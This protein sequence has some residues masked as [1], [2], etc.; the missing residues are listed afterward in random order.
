[1]NKRSIEKKCRSFF[2]FHEYK[3]DKMTTLSAPVNN[4]ISLV[5]SLQ[6]RSD[7]E[8]DM[9]TW[10]AQQLHSKASGVAFPV[11]FDEAWKRL[12][13]SRKDVAKRSLLA[14]NLDKNQLEIQYFA[15]NGNRLN[16]LEI[17]LHQK[18]VNLGGARW[19]EEI[20]LSVD[21]FD[22]FAMAVNKSAR[23]VFSRLKDGVFE[24]GTA[25]QCGEVELKRTAPDDSRPVKRIKACES[26]KSL[27][28]VLKANKVHGAVYAM[29]NGETNKAVTGLYKSELAK[30]LGL[31]NTQVN[32][33][34]YMTKAQLI[35][36]ELA[37]VYS[38]EVMG[39]EGFKGD[40]VETHKTVL[41]EAIG[42]AMRQRLLHG[43]RAKKMDLKTARTPVAVTIADAPPVAAVAVVDVPVAAAPMC[44]QH[45]AT[46]KNYFCARPNPNLT[47]AQTQTNE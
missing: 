15:R 8:R 47:Q 11:S 40:P 13:C 16:A 44:V 31:R 24:L 28:A 45:A 23:R 36:L 46:I 19:R 25:I 33:R 18:A 2:V 37:E 14:L 20:F 30:E 35:A 12:G 21:G 26:Q 1:M 6:P 43:K 32:A 4:M 5:D 38:A 29:V 22:E 34:D 27:S 7:A 17:D 10:M 39:V 41:A 42:L 3:E 9:M